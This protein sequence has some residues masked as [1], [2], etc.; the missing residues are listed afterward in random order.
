MPNNL[1][2]I[3]NFSIQNSKYAN[4]YKIKKNSYFKLLKS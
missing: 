2:N 4:S 1:I 3:I